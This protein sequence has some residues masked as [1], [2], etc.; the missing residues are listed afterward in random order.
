MRA[1]PQRSRLQHR[2]TPGRARNRIAMR[3]RARTPPPAAA[4]GPIEGY[5]AGANPS[6]VIPATRRPLSDVRGRAF[7]RHSAA[8]P[9]PAFAPLS[10]TGLGF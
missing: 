10:I 4:D 1:H 3:A 2:Q 6:A 7:L 9:G 8:S 5:F